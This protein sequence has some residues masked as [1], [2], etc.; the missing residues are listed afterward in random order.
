MKKFVEI[1]IPILT[2][3][4]L[5]IFDR[6]DI[7]ANWAEEQSCQILKE[8]LNL[9]INLVVEFIDSVTR[10]AEICAQNIPQFGKVE[11]VVKVPEIIC[12][13]NFKPL[14]F[15]FLGYLLK[16]DINSSNAA[17][18]KFGENHG[19]LSSLIGL[20]RLQNNKFTNS[21][22]T[23]AYVNCF[24]DKEKMQLL[25]RLFFR[26]PIVQK[27]IR[28]SAKGTINGYNYMLQLKDSTIIRRGS[29]VKKILNYI[30]KDEEGVV[31]SR[32]DNIIWDTKGI[33]HES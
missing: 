22:I 20:T 31:V 26:V 15:A 3:A 5:L 28:E 6:I 16:N 24:D 18:Q 2:A 23:Y 7:S 29:S 30:K 32:I 33:R 4:I 17:N 8:L 19:K 13:K 21:A 9:D 11:T 14:D 10:E 1:K 25:K 27:L 12:K